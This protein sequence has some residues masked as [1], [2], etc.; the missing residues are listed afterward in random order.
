[1]SLRWSVLLLAACGGGGG[2]AGPDGGASGP[3][4]LSQARIL[5][6]GVGSTENDCRAGICQHLEDTDVTT[7]NGAIYLVFRSAKSQV[8]G[9]NS[10]LRVYRSTDKGATFDLTAVLP[11][12]EDRDLR[13]PCF[14]TIGDKLAIKGLT[15]LP[16]VST[17]DSNVD[18][19]TVATT[20][21][22]GTHWSGFV[23]ISPA[24]WSYWRIRDFAGVHYAAA[25]EDG[26]KSVKLFSSTDGLQWTAGAVIYGVSAD[27]PLE[28][29]IVFMPSGRML[30]LVRMDGTTDELL[31][32]VGRLRTKVCWATP[33]Y[34][35]FDC[36][37]ELT[38]VR[39]DGPVAF[40][41]GPKLYVIAR[42][43]FI[44]DADRKRNALYA[45]GG[46][47]EGGP[48]T[49]QELGELPSAGDTA[50]TGVADLDANRV[51]A[52]WYS[53]ELAADA[54]WGRAILDGS[55]IWRGEIDF[56]KIK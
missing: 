10:S 9:P 19:I 42:K 1:V 53:S 46:T 40:F 44:E 35:S 6:P 30:A 28:T 11:A 2:G 52:I 7:W 8:L 31:G 32:N 43:H 20:S 3:A 12:P 56:S 25:Y 41:H 17:R 27:T 33:P 49:I 14:Y 48:L 24:T 47:L 45:I 55:D 38:G 54:P 50:Y 21:E 18:T 13:D 36:P 37:Q 15:R 5:V 34:G 4:W 26:D 23:P 39:L 51:I 29:E 22:D 16:V